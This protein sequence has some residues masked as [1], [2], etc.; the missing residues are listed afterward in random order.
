M[1]SVSLLGGEHPLSR[2]ARQ[3]RQHKPNKQHNPVC[4]ITHRQ[5]LR[6]CR[7]LPLEKP[8]QSPIAARRTLMLLSTALLGVTSNIT[9]AQHAWASS[10]DKVCIMPFASKSRL[11]RL[12]SFRI[13][14]H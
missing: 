9:T 11:H 12:I 1:V 2:P 13:L 8:M 4:V 3:H 10:E 7:A 6:P 5:R 14:K